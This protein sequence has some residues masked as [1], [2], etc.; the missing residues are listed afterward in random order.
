M[1]RIVAA[2]ILAAALAGAACSTDTATSTTFG[3]EG[4]P[5][6]VR[7]TFL[8]VARQ[9]AL[10][11][12]YDA[13][14]DEWLDFAREVCGADIGTSADLVELVDNRTGPDDNPAFKQMWISVGDA[15]TASFCPIERA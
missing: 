8:T 12:G 3:V 15:A 9:A 11:A 4:A 2:M 7:S 1:T 14:S 13:T 6:I 5:Q 10:L